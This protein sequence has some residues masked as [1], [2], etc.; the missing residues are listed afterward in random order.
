M[1]AAESRIVYGSVKPVASEEQ[2]DLKSESSRTFSVASASQ[3]NRRDVIAVGRLSGLILRAATS[4][5]AGPGDE[6]NPILSRLFSSD[7]VISC[8]LSFDL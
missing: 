3:Q 2:Q 6:P 8:H 5:D 1:F 4:D 7:L